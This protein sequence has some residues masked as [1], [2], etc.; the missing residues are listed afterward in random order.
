MDE[1]TSPWTCWGE[2]DHLVPYG[3]ENVPRVNSLGGQQVFLS[4]DVSPLWFP[5]ETDLREGMR[6][7]VLT[8]T[9]VD[10]VGPSP[11]LTFT[12]DEGEVVSAPDRISTDRGW[13]HKT[14]R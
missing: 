12:W 5:I 7:S 8:W 6:I 10:D 14:R 3:K 2:Q 13:A 1:K 11:V 9:R 4:T